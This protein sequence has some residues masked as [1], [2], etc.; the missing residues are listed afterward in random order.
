MV[1]TLKAVFIT[2]AILLLMFVAYASFWLL[3]LGV[4]ATAIYIAIK[5][6]ISDTDDDDDYYPLDDD[7]LKDMFKA[8]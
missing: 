8:S 1:N 7:I 6:Y 4:V 5:I 3:V 2:T